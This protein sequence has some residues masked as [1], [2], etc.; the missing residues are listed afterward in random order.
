M[1]IFILAKK[2]NGDIRRDFTGLVIIE[3]DGYPNPDTYDMPNNGIY[4]FTAQD[5]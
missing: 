4:Q 5:Q 1:D 3:I 2:A